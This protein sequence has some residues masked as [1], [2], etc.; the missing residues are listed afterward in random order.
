MVFTLVSVNS[1]KKTQLITFDVYV[2]HK[3][4]DLDLD[5]NNSFYT[6]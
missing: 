3:N 2:K 1:K 6:F 4:P 5:Y